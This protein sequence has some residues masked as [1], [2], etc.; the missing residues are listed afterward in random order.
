VAYYDATND[1]LKYARYNG[2]AWDVM[3]IADNG[4]EYCSL[5]IDANWLPHISY[6]ARE[7]G[8]LRYATLIAD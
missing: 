5:A 1:A 7:V 2:L 4:G 8:N 3:T 6:Y